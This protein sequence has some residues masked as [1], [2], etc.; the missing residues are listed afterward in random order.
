MAEDPLVAKFAAHPVREQLRNQLARVQKQIDERLATLD[1]NSA[2]RLQRLHRLLA[3]VNAVVE[4]T[5]PI[6]AGTAGLDQLKQ[7]LDLIEPQFTAFES[8]NAGTL[9]AALAQADAIIPQLHRFPAK[10][11]VDDAVAYEAVTAKLR[12]EQTKILSDVQKSA[13]ET[14]ETVSAS[15][16]AAHSKIEQHVSSAEML[17][18]TV[19]QLQQQIG[20]QSGRLDA[21]LTKFTTDTASLEQQ[22]EKRFQEWIAKQTEGIETR[23]TEQIGKITALLQ[24]SEQSASASIDSL[25]QTKRKAAEILNVIGNIGATGNYKLT[26]DANEKTANSLRNGAVLL[27][28]AMV[29]TVVTLTINLVHNGIDWKV[30]AFRLFSALILALPAAYLARESARHREVAERMRRMELELASI[31]AFN[32]LLPED[33]RNAIKGE[34]ARR[35]FG[36]VSADSSATVDPDQ[37]MTLKEFFKELSSL[38]TAFRK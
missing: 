9:K 13:S 19:E 26:A 22:R 6:V 21:A 23:S 30:A 25:E 15:L 16:Q 1:A 4:S 36:N 35:Y 31:D 24:K 7:F 38:V 34:M 5:D 8:G 20:Q 37:Q 17:G 14:A 10:A 33:Q 29:V 2:G 28:L 11:D 3:Y 12:S 18:K 32:A 27:F